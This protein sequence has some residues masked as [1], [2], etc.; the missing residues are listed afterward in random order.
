[1]VLEYDQNVL[2]DS[3]FMNFQTGPLYYHQ[4]NHCRTSV[5]HLGLDC[6][7]EYSDANQGIMP[8]YY[9]IWV[10]CMESDFDNTIQGHVPSSLEYYCS[11]TQPNEIVQLLECPPTR[12]MI[13]TFS[14][15]CRTPNNG[16]YVL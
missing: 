14:M 16:Y 15:R 1:M 12:Q 3:I 13:S 8:E 4:P 6:K 7:V 5:D 9:N 2:R 10:Q 11:W